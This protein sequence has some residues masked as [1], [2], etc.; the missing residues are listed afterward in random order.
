M[1]TT[2][3]S[4]FLLLQQCLV[5][6]IWMVFLMGGSSRT[7]DVLWNVASRIVQ[8]SSSHSCAIALKLFLQ[9]LS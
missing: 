5:R 8:Y 7:A 4:S 1:S 3:M 2:L 9:T 6:L